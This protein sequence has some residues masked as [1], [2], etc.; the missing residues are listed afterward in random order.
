MNSRLSFIMASHVS[1]SMTK[2][3]V[4]W[5]FREN[6]SDFWEDFEG[7]LGF[8]SEE[9]DYVMS[10]KLH[11]VIDQVGGSD[12]QHIQMKQDQVWNVFFLVKFVSRGVQEVDERINSVRRIVKH[13]HNSRGVFLVGGREG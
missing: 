2:V 11:K 7:Q 5:V 8:A 6:F 4:E 3:V 10:G 13:L 1:C 9:L 12:N